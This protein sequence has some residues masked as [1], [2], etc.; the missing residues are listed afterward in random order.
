MLW[1]I[2]SLILFLCC[3]LE[4]FLLLLDHGIAAQLIITA[5]NMAAIQGW[6]AVGA[7]ILSFVIGKIRDVT[8]SSK[9]SK[10]FADDSVY[11]AFC[12]SGGLGDYIISA[13]VLEN[14]QQICKCSIDVFCEKQQFGSAVYGS[15]EDVCLRDY[16][17][18]E[19]SRNSYDLGLLVEHFVHV[20]NY[21]GRRLRELSPVLYEK[22]QYIVTHWNQLYVNIPQQHWRERIQFE[23]CRV[24]GLDRWTQLRM[25][26]AFE[27][28]DKNVFIPMDKSFL[29]KWKQEG[30][31]K[32][33]YLTI[34]YGADVM[35]AGFNQLKMW[36]REYY[37]KLVKLIHL[38]FPN[39]KVVQLGGADTEAV[40]G[41][42]KYVLG[43]SIEQTK[44][45]L[46]SS[47]VHIDCEGGLV[48]LATQLGTKCIVIF[49]PT[50]LHMYGY[51]ENINLQSEGCH[52][53]MGVYGDWAYQCFKTG[54][55]T[56]CMADITPEMVLKSVKRVCQR[57]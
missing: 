55:Y 6:K 48:H 15:R 17:E 46:K 38:E 5:K 39:M 33:E 29:E 12:P 14:I 41:C 49:G 51:E 21:N 18:F 23:R 10:H 9:R 54:S 32:G 11:I 20:K 2:I 40:E 47:Q 30:F 50:P 36:Y 26:E 1:I 56:Q 45:I 7:S 57:E 42:D 31:A 25:G 19:K 8:G 43:E 35:R 34:N 53:C 24:L 28:A 13:K 16:R 37:V 27:I 52:N 44:W 22:V 3:L 4:V